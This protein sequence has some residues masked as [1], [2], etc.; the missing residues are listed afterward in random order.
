MFFILR[1]RKRRIESAKGH[2]EDAFSP[3]N[4]GSLHAPGTSH[5]SVNSAS[6]PHTHFTQ[7]STNTTSLFGAGHYERPETVSTNDTQSRIQQPQPTPN[8]FADPGR[9]KAFDQIR[10]RPRSTTL[11]DRGS[12]NQN[13]FQDPL[14]DRFDPFGQLQEKARAERVRYREEIER[15]RA[16]QYAE[17]EAMGLGLDADVYG[18]RR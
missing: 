5:M 8:P 13:P 3:S 10:G 2:A 9:N 17:K 14:S 12:W 6:D 18:A 15:E 4:N 7:T 1:R 11:T 16:Q